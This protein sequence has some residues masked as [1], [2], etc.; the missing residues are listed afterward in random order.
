MNGNLNEIISK[1]SLII[2]D[3][4]YLPEVVDR[5]SIASI[6]LH[7]EKWISQFD[8]EDREFVLEHTYNLL[9]ENYYSETRYDN[10]LRGVAKNRKNEKWK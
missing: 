9:S 5:K 2:K 3:Y 6:D 10:L 8:L 4:K 7:V 1:I